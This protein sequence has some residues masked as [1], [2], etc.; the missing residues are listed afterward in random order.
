MIEPRVHLSLPLS[1]A[2]EL[3]KS[4]V[5]HYL[6]DETLRK[7]HGLEST[8][9]PESITQLEQ[10]LNIS[11]EDALRD[12]K[13]A[14]DI[15]WRYSWLSYT[16]EWAWQRAQKETLEALG[17]RASSE[18]PE[19]DIEALIERHYEKHFERYQQEISLHE[20]IHQP[21]RKNKAQSQKKV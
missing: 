21:G 20:T 15:L 10:L 1:D 11:S 4:A 18:L 5:T 16:D 19:K 8:P 2:L 6:V 3:Y 17:P 12:A 9:L 14:E 7:E 13:R